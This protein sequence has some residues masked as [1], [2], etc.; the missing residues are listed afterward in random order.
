M[1]I[2]PCTYP[3][4]GRTHPRHLLRESYRE[5]SKVQQ[6]TTANLSHTSHNEIQTMKLALKHKQNLSQHGRINEHIHV[7]QKLSVGVVTTLWQLAKR[8][9]V[10]QG[11]G[12]S[13]NR[14]Q[15]LG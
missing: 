4:N 3:I 10:V 14:K 15:A 1:F 9:G 2:H 13:P 5:H 12:N 6:R 7:Q 11:L 8:L